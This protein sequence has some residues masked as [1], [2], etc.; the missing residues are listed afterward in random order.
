MRRKERE[1]TDY[2]KMIEIL[3]LCDCCRIGL[4]DDKGAYIVPMNFG[5]ENGTFYLHSGPEGKKT[6]LIRNDN[7]ISLS[8][9][10]NTKLVF[11]HPEVACSYSMSAESIICE[12]KVKFITDYDEKIRCLNIIMRHYTNRE[13]KYNAPAVNNICI[14][15]I[16]PEQIFCKSFGN[17][18]K[19]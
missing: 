13:F 12:G 10:G 18:A 6:E 14:W 16:K 9:H 8:L 15:E 11:Q 4:V 7:R 3:K 17:S 19:R 5:Y 2:N 1:V